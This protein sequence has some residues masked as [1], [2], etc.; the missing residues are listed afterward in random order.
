MQAE[1]SAQARREIAKREKERL[2]LQEK[3]RKANLEKLRNEQGDQAA[4]DDVAISSTARY[5]PR[6]CP[7][8]RLSQMLNTLQLLLL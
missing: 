2:R 6:Y 8:K 4:I 7:T 3:Q 1:T 5:L